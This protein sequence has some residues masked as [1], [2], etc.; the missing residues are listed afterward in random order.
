MK[1]FKLPAA[2]RG[3]LKNEEFTGYAIFSLGQP[4]TRRPAGFGPVYVFNDDTLLP[5]SYLGMHPHGN[6]EIITI[7]I[8]G[9]ESHEDT[10]GVH[11]NYSKGDVQLISAGSGLMHAGGNPSAKENARHL[12][13]WVAPATLNTSPQVRVLKSSDKPLRDGYV[14]LLV[15]PDGSEGSLQL[16]QEIRISEIGLPA[17]G[18]YTLPAPGNNHG[19]MLYVVEGQTTVAGDNLEQGDTLFLTDPDYAEISTAVNSASLILIETP[20]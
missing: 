6:V 11:E 18:S 7:I 19:Y 15:S 5:G 8:S 16:A 13:I 9:E 1:T 17:L 10:L 4:K 3:L 2:E 12:Q 14:T 20:L